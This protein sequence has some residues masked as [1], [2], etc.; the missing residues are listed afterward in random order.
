MKQKEAF[1]RG[2]GDAWFK[3]N[4]PALSQRALPDEDP[5][6]LEILG[7]KKTLPKR[8]SILEIGCGPGVRLAW[9]RDNLNYVCYGIEPSA[10]AVKSAKHRRV[11]ARVG[12]ADHLPYGQRYFD[13]VIFGFCLYLCDREDLFQIAAE[14]DRVLKSPGWLL[15]L[16]FYHPTPISREYHHRAGVQSYKMD[17]RTLF[18][19]HPS[20][21]AYSHKVE[22]H[23]G[24][25]YTDNPLDWTS[26]SVL[27]KKA[28][29]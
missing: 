10:N 12:T 15:I 24:R 2:E 7:L 6:V 8:A 1:L 14:A 25:G 5:I 23:H 11:H 27:R 26:L 22:Q 28:H 16:D 13:V 29:R 18:T 21:C 20:Y 9:L 19:W 3:R 4:A 17:Y